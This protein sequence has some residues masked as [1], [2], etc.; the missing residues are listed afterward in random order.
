MSSSLSLSRFLAAFAAFMAPLVILMAY[1]I[2]GPPKRSGSWHEVP[3]PIAANSLQGL[4]DDVRAAA[5][6]IIDWLGSSGATAQAAY[7]KVLL[8][9]NKVFVDSYD[10]DESGCRLIFRASRLGDAP[11]KRLAVTGN[12]ADELTV[13]TKPSDE[14]QC[15]REV[16]YVRVIGDV[17]R[18]SRP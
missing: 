3:L 13:P 14:E 11:I 4:P 1:V 12:S 7:M 2:V 8:A 16:S 9:G 5:K 18:P 15:A 10:I 6:P 17:R